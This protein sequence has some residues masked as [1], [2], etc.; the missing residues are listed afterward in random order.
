[1]EAAGRFS[2]TVLVRVLLVRALAV[3][4]FTAVGV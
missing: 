4:G 1:M 3:A 2:A